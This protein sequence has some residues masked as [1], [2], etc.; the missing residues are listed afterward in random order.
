[1]LLDAAKGIEEQ[2]LKLFQ[3]AR[4]R[5]IPLITFVNKLDRPALEPLALTDEIER[6]LGLRATPVTWPVGSAERFAG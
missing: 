3:V 2:T 1:M 6:E 4:E 5:R